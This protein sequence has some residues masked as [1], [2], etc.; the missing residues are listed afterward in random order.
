MSRDHKRTRACFD[1]CAIGIIRTPFTEATGTPIQPSYA[2][3]EEGEVVVEETYA[4]A[5]DDIEDFDRLWLI[6]W[7]DRAGKFKQRVVPYRDDREHGLFATRSPCR[8]NPIGI[9]VV[10]LVRRKERVLYVTD[11]DILDRTPLLDIK[12]YVPEFDAQ[13]V[14]KAGWFDACGTDRKVA[15]DRFHETVRGTFDNREIATPPYEVLSD[16]GVVLML[17]KSCIET[18][19][20][21]ARGELVAACLEGSGPGASI[22]EPIELMRHFLEATDFGELRA[23]HPELAGGTECRVKLLRCE[24]GSVGWWLF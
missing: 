6:Y 20:K 16:G 18:A 15:D 3:G 14:S 10:R 7:M 2:R 22:E 24:D 12:P 1:L 4:A 19:V 11:V 13:P 21:R 9:S 23:R 17:D 5:L 8:P